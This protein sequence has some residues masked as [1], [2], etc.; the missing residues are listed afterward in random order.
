MAD[1]HRGMDM[2]KEKGSPKVALVTECHVMFICDSK[3]VNFY[4]INKMV[5]GYPVL[6]VGET[7][8]FLKE[9]GI[10]NFLSGKKA[11]VFEINHTMAKKVSIV[12]SSKI[13]RIAKKVI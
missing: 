7:K 11:G 4:E 3:K 12:I 9:G 6:T 13:L 1:V 2:S 8:G 10:I 5:K